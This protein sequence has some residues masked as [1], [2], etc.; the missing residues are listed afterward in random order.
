MINFNLKKV[1]KEKNMTLKELSTKTG[2]SINTLSLLSTGKS[3]G[4]QFD[5]LEKLIHA[6][7]CNVK[8]LVLVDDGFKTLKVIDIEKSKYGAFIFNQQKDN[9][10]HYFNC[11]YKE[12][13]E[14][15]HSILLTILFSDE[16]IEVAISGEFPREF[17]K[18]GKY[19]FKSIDSGKTKDFITLDSLFITKIIRDCYIE[20]E[21][22]RKL[23]NFKN[24]KIIF[25]LMPYKNS[26][27]SIVYKD[28]KDF[29]NRNLIP[30]Y[31]YLKDL[32]FLDKDSLKISNNFYKEEEIP[33]E[34][35]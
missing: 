22:I 25:N 28:E 21:G 23:F 1:M 31:S 32:V 33:E 6:L 24:Q 20:F 7:D 10:I 14:N 15:E 13:D 3:K 18:S 34:N 2:L 26:I 30:A 17:L 11:T 4:I 12:N 29:L 9:R 27:I 16:Y 5:T 19:C 8:D 35:I